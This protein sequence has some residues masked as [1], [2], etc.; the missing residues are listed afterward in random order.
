MHLKLKLISKLHEPQ[1][2]ICITLTELET[3]NE[4]VFIIVRMWQHLWV[5]DTIITVIFRLERLMLYLRISKKIIMYKFVNSSVVRLS[6]NICKCYICV[7]E[8]LTWMFQRS[9]DL[10][11]VKLLNIKSV[12]K[13]FIF[14]QK[15]MVTKNPKAYAM[16]IKWGVLLIFSSVDTVF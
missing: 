14:N 1:E 15:C 8:R 3:G 2:N 6:F 12:F 7:V 5:D 10:S 9:K 4:F 16:R 13:C 11:V